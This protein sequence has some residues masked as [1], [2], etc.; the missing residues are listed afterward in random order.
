MEID[1]LYERYKEETDIEND[2]K[3]L[4]VIIYGSRTRENYKN[5]SDLDVLVI[6][7]PVPDNKQAYFHESRLID[8]IPVETILLTF[9][10]LKKSIIS[11]FW[12]NNSLYESVFNTGI[13]KKDKS[14][15]V[16]FIQTMIKDLRERNVLKDSELN[17]SWQIEITT[18]LEKYRSASGDYKKY[19]YS[20]LIEAVREIYHFMHNY[21]EIPVWKVYD[22]YS[23]P[24]KFEDEYKLVLPPE[25]FR[26]DFLEALHFYDM[27]KHIENLFSFIGFTKKNEKNDLSMHYR[28]SKSKYQIS[29]I[30]MHLGKNV[31]KV[32]DALLYNSPASDFLYFQILYFLYDSCWSIGPKDMHEFEEKF[33]LAMSIKD[34]EERISYVEELFHIV[35]SEYEFD[36][37]N[38]SL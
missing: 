30:L 9:E 38:Y 17:E 3:S 1:E 14:G 34:S 4:A 26:N 24:I 8:G 13:V 32:E 7:P 2:S 20:N 15:I 6:I 31:Y 37:D 5:G 36:Y 28:P 11:Y 35:N 16:P 27:D 33:M 29:D 10:A 23:N 18:R 19:C 22:I 12:D 21:S 25:N